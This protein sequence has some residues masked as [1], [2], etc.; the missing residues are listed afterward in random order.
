MADGG[1]MKIFWW[2]NGLHFEPETDEERKALA[3]L[4]AASKLGYVSGD[5]ESRSGSGELGQ[6]LPERVVASP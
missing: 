3:L 6:Q 1:I 2:Q 5:A 4:L